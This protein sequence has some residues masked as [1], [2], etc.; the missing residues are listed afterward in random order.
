MLGEA[1]VG[2]IVDVDDTA[3]EEEG[4]GAE[5]VFSSC[6]FETPLPSADAF[7]ARLTFEAT[8]RGG[9]TG[10]ETLRFEDARDEG[11]LL[12]ESEREGLGEGAREDEGV[13][14]PA[15]WSSFVDPVTPEEV[16]SIGTAGAVSL[17]PPSTDAPFLSAVC[18]SSTSSRVGDGATGLAGCTT[19]TVGSMG[20]FGRLLPPSDRAYAA[21]KSNSLSGRACCGPSVLVVPASEKSGDRTEA[22]SSS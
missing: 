18:D 17:V 2:S 4:G 7:V 15:V 20:E 1:I 8:L 10:L 3:S 13:V 22:I 9:R 12:G 11:R 21:A 19:P 16:G 5:S 14:F 6:G